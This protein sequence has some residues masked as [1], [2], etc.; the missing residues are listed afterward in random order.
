MANRLRM[1]SR[2]HIIEK[3]YLDKDIM[4]AIS[5]M[6]PVDLQEDL[7]QEM[8][9]VLC[10]MPEEKLLQ[11]YND[12]YLKFFLVRTMLNMIKSD[13]STFHNK[14]RKV[15]EEVDKKVDKAEVIDQELEKISVKLN[16]SINVLHWYEQEIF[17]LYSENGKNITKLSRQTRIPYRSLFKVIRKVRTYLKYKIRNHVNH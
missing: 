1:L 10:E 4:Q 7:R 8:F 9:L 15:F 16:S 2:N 11:M 14:F 17:R 6:Q 12:G 13:R 3:L 5:K